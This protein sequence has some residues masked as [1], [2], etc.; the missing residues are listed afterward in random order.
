ML[1]IDEYGNRMN[2]KKRQTLQ[3]SI[4]DLLDARL[5]LVRTGSA[6][7]GEDEGRPDNPIESQIG[8]G[9]TGASPD[10]GPMPD[11][12]CVCGNDCCNQEL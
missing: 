6:V 10:N 12:Q 11:M 2:W 8:K 1:K 7:V 4:D 3:Q 5:N 9:A